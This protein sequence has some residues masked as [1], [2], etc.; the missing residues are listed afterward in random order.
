MTVRAVVAVVPYVVI[1]AQFSVGAPE[2]AHREVGDALDVVA[3]R[4]EEFAA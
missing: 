3:E 4:G 2:T 1:D